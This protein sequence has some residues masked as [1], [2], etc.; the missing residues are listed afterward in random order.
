[1]ASSKIKEIKEG[2]AVEIIHYIGD[3]LWNILYHPWCISLNAYYAYF[4]SIKIIKISSH[5][6]VGSSSLLI[7]S[8]P[9]SPI[10]LAVSSFSYLID[11]FSSRA[12]FLSY[13]ICIFVL[14]CY[15]WMLF[16]CLSLSFFILISKNV[17][18]AASLFKPD[19]D[20]T[21]LELLL[22]TNEIF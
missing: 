14:Y 12:S 9:N 16:N 5:S 1:M 3:S 4:Q 15:F 2:I 6:S 10:N 20:S 13:Q 18:I 17:P 22:P 19:A 21:W 7:S 8:I 11:Y